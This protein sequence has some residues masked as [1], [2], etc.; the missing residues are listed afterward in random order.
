MLA[1][2]NAGNYFPTRGERLD[3]LNFP[4]TYEVNCSASLNGLV[5]LAERMRE[6]GRGH[7]AVVASVTSYFG[8]PTTA[9][10]GA[11]KA[12]L[13]NMAEALKYDFDKLNIRIQVINPGFVDTPLTA[14]TAS[15][16]GA[17]AGRSRRGADCRGAQVRRLRDHLPAPLHLVPQIPAHPA[18]TA[19]LLVHQPRDGLAHAP[20]PDRQAR[21]RS[22][23]D[24][25][26]QLHGRFPAI[27][28]PSTGAAARHQWR[29]RAQPGMVLPAGF[30]MLRHGRPVPRQ[31]RK[32]YR[33]RLRVSIARRS[34]PC[35][36]SSSGKFHI[37]PIAASFSSIGSQA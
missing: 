23:A 19:A 33:I 32:P 37:S 25:A 30:A 26:E 36:I 24:S 3:V 2:F 29:R 16:A 8:W 12:A 1:V 10:Y 22:R 15:D 35:A 34:S 7:I 28:V 18:A 14:R 31:P 5:P 9:A 20:H 13:N 11:S 21:L 6:R 17:D 27:F 4:R